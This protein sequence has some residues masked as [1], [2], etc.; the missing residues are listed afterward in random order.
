M[1][2]ESGP[3]KCGCFGHWKLEFGYCLLFDIWCLGFIRIK[4]ADWFK[5]HYNF[6]NIFLGHSTSAPAP[7]PLRPALCAMPYA[8]C[9]MP[10]APCPLHPALCAM[11]YAPCAL[12]YAPC[13]MRHA[14]CP[15]P[16]APCAM[17]YA[18]CALPSAP[19]PMRQVRSR[20][21]FSICPAGSARKI[22]R[23]SAV[24]IPPGLPRQSRA[25]RRRTAC[26]HTGV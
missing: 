12:P 6:Y 1:I 26:R 11:P 10:Y 18:L 21:W 16:H 23:T 15:L 8:P 25:P 4:C 9:A 7:C 20:A 5:T 14:L 17:P 2:Q 22:P 3:G 13:P 24:K 19:C